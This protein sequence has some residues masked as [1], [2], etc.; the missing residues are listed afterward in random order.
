[1][2]FVCVYGAVYY[3]IIMFVRF[4]AAFFLTESYKQRAS[5]RIFTLNIYMYI[6]MYNMMMNYNVSQTHTHVPLLLSFHF[7]VAC[8]VCEKVIYL[9]LYHTYIYNYIKI[10]ASECGT[11]R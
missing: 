11:M 9:I 3:Y 10:H 7:T 5:K 4:C 2:N 1:M 8:L 6:I